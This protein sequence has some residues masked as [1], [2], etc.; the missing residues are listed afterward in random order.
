MSFQNGWRG[1]NIVSDGLVLYLDAASPNSYRSDFGNNWKDMSGN[2][3]V[4]YLL[5]GTVFS[6]ENGGTMLFDGVD[7]YT[8]G[9]ININLGTQVTLSTWVYHNTIPTTV[10]RYVS[11]PGEAAVIRHD[12]A[13]T[14]GGQLHFYISTG[15]VLRLNCRANNELSINNWYNVV[16]T[17]DGTIMRLYKNGTQ[18]AS[19]TPPTATLDSVNVGYII[20][21]YWGEAM[22]G[23]IPNIQIYNKALTS[24]EVTQN[25]NALKSRFGL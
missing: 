9:S 12:G 4:N 11:L 10:Q 3:G 14:G 2:G 5:N 7:D 23:K 25:Y 15:G 18:V 8:S 22:N 21:A 13:N 17:W 19:D 24:S 16:G 20:S 1:P 6:S